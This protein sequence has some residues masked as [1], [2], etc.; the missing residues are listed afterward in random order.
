ME[1]MD[2]ILVGFHGEGKL[3]QGILSL[4]LPHAPIFF[5]NPVLAAH[6][7]GRSLPCSDAPMGVEPHA[8]DVFFSWVTPPVSHRY[9]RKK[10]IWPR[11]QSQKAIILARK[12]KKKSRI[13]STEIRRNFCETFLLGQS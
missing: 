4:D 10:R 2:D 7:V 5:N 6:Q 11:F 13:F 1:T 8:P 3:K 9:N 12:T